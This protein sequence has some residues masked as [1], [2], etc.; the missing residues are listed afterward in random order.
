MRELSS[1]VCMQ[2]KLARLPAKREV[3]SLWQ[4]RCWPT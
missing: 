2:V 1:W 3:D 4:L